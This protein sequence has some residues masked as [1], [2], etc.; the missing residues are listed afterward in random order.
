MM[1]CSLGARQVS[2]FRSA[3]DTHNNRM[4]EEYYDE[5]GNK[6]DSS[7]DSIWNFHVW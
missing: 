2:N 7:P 6:D 4:I 1:E 3:H 5:E